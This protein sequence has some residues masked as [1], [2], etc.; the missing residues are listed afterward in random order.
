MFSPSMA[1]IASVRS[2][3]IF[4]FCVSL[5]TPS[6]SFTLIRGMFVSLV[7]RGF[8]A[9]RRAEGRIRSAEF[10]EWPRRRRS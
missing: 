5:K 10:G 1:T 9:S 2:V 4:F 8:V 7:G 6:M 3:T